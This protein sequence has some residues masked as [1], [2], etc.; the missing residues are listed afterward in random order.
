MDQIDPE[1]K[2]TTI[3]ERSEQR[4]TPVNEI[5]A[6]LHA[7]TSAAKSVT[8]AQTDSPAPDV[9]A[10]QTD[11]PAERNSTAAQADTPAGQSLKAVVS[12]DTMTPPVAP[13]ADASSLPY[14]SA[15]GD[16]QDI[17]KNSAPLSAYK[18]EIWASSNK[19]V[20]EK[21]QLREIGRAANA[22][23]EN[24]GTIVVCTMCTCAVVAGFYFFADSYHN[25]ASSLG[26]HWNPPVE[27]AP[28]LP[29]FLSMFKNTA[30][31]SEVLQLLPYA[32]LASFI[33][34]GIAAMAIYHTKAREITCD[35]GNLILQ[36]SGPVM[37]GIRWKAIKEIEQSRTWDIFN[38]KRDVLKVETNGGETFRMRVTDIA[39]KQDIGTFFNRVR[40]CA[41]QAVLK[42]ADEI[43]LAEPSYTELWLKYFSAPSERNNK[44][45]LEPGMTLDS[46]RYRI[47]ETV[48]G[49][50]Q[51][52]AYLA[53]CENPCI[54]E[55]TGVEHFVSEPKMSEQAPGFEIVLKEYVLPVHRGQATAEKTAEKLKGEAAI[56]RR[57]DHPQIVKLLDGFIEDYRGY[58]VLEYVQGESLKTL[59]ERL[60]PQP[61]AEVVRWALQLADILSYL[62]GLTPSVV[63]RDITPDNIILQETGVV[64]VVDFNVAHQVDSSATATVVG[65]HAYIPPEQFRGKPTE[66]SD[67]YALGGTMFYLLTA[68]EPEP[69]SVSRPAR[70]G[71]P[72][73]EALDAIIAK[74]TAL[75]LGKRYIDISAFRSD[76]LALD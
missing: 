64:K 54:A 58:L 28:E 61:E 18:G 15:G 74:A 45:L 32:V 25:A 21:K 52:T 20:A 63:H 13:T 38:G 66:Q 59:V 57:L 62:H 40:T 3:A 41:P 36:G 37:I 8:A 23:L 65:K 49:G 27:A 6:V 68:T 75:D 46:G 29:E 51:G 26:V 43:R 10:A 67:I 44:G 33:A 71:A 17:F 53:A 76:L 70:H 30:S 11:T 16:D 72:V 34:L 73:S 14:A 7:D 22:I 31:M 56:L 69:I 12:E 9:T 2:P 35:D 48:G 4:L 5:S 19:T 55:G 60:G 50:G 47:I 42:I 1:S 24:L 39:R